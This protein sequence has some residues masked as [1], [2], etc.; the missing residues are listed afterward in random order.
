MNVKDERVTLFSSPSNCK[1]WSQTSSTSKSLK[2]SLLLG[3]FEFRMKNSNAFFNPR[4]TVSGLWKWPHFVTSFYQL[5]VC[6]FIE[7]FIQHCKVQNTSWLIDHLQPTSQTIHFPIHFAVLLYSTKGNSSTR[8]LDCDEMSVIIH[9]CFDKYRTS[10]MRVV[11]CDTIS[12]E[13]FYHHVFG[14][15]KTSKNII[16]IKQHI[17]N[18][19]G[20]PKSCFIVF[21]SLTKEK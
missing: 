8:L 14:P 7:S 17:F 1:N 12:R 21:H 18:G 4:P 3:L 19:T 20:N 9:D 11:K 5:L 10:D 6:F 2:S 16:D 13:N 15:I